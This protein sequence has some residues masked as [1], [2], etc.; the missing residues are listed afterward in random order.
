MSSGILEDAPPWWQALPE[1]EMPHATDVGHICGHSRDFHDA[2]G[3]CLIDH[4]SISLGGDEGKDKKTG[5]T[6][7]IPTTTRD[8][9]A[10]KCPGETVWHTLMW[11]AGVAW[12]TITDDEIF[13]DEQREKRREIAASA[14]YDARGNYRWW[15]EK[16]KT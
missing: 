9:P 10:C 14:K 3:R 5:Q 11:P 1:A 2:E 12:D 6:V 13:S 8:R 15:V 4:R 16:K 7:I